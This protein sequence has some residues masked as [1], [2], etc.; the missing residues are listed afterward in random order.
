MAKYAQGTQVGSDR[1]RSEIERTLQRYGAT[2]FAYGWHQTSA[3]IAFEAKGRRIRFELPL[4]DRASK[5]FM[6]TP[7][8]KP[9]S[10]QAAADAYEQ[11]V[12]QKWRALALA[13]KAK[14]EAVESGI[15]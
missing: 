10:S 14:L 3:I 7:T 6:R 9:R 5:A 15:S 11:A 4:P 2:S 12:R 1:S 8:G 13:I